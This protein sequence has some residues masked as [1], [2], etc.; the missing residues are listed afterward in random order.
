VSPIQCVLY[1]V[2]ALMMVASPSAWS[3]NLDAQALK[4]YGGTYMVDC[5]NNA[6]AKV[7]VFANALVFLHG[8]Q[9]VA[10]NSIETGFSYFHP[11]PNPKGF[12]VTLINA[13][14]GGLEMLWHVFQDSSGQYLVFVDADAKSAT[15]IGKAIAKQKFRRCDGGASI[16]LAIPAA[17]APAQAQRTYALHELSAPGLLMDPTAKA[18]YY[19]ALGSLRRENWLAQLDGPSPQ[20]KLVTVLGTRYTL[21]GACKNHDCYDNSVALL[22]SADQGVLYGQVVQRGRS[23]LIGAPSP[24]LA[25]ELERI[26]RQEW[27]SNPR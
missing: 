22:Y 14:P 7:S 25:K 4:N 13:G 27:R 16:K 6:S 26:W 19:K 8:N 9:R 5:K 3:Q 21:A 2:T 18:L 1:G 11:N 24:A 17:T 20:N 15:V 12:L 23:T 10:S